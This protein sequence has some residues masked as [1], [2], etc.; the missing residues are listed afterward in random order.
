MSWEPDTEEIRLGKVRKELDDLKAST[1]FLNTSINEGMSSNALGSG[2]GVSSFNQGSNGDIPQQIENVLEDISGT[3][4]GIVDVIGSLLVINPAS[5]NEQVANQSTIRKLN[6]GVDGQKTVIK[7]AKGKTVKLI[8]NPNTNSS[9]DGNL[10]LGADLVLTD[11]ESVTLRFTTDIL[12][13]DS[14]ESGDPTKAEIQKIGGW[15]IESTGSGSGNST[16]GVLKDPV[17][18]A[19]TGNNSLHPA[20][21]S[22][23]DGI[24]MVAGD[25]FLV[26]DQTTQA[27]NGIYIWGTGT[28]GVSVR[29]SDMSHGSVQKEGTMTYVQDGLTQNE[30][31]YAINIGGNNILIGTNPNTWGEIGSGSGGGSGSIKSPVKV[32]TT[33]DVT[34]WTYNNTSGTL[35]ASGNGV[36]VI[37][38]ITLAVNNRI[39]VKNQSPANENGIYSV[40]TAGAVGA[41]LVLTRSTDM[42]TGST[43]EGG[44]M[45]YVTDGTVNG[46]NL[47]GLTTEGTV[48][49]GTGNQA[50]ANLTAG[51]VGTATS[52]LN[53]NGNAILDSTGDLQINDD[54]DMLIHKIK[55]I[56]QLWYDATGTQSI[57]STSGGI[58]LKVP[59]GD[60]ID[61]FVNSTATPK[62]GITE[63]SVES[64]VRLDMNLNY[65]E[66]QEIST[67]STPT[68]NHGLIYAKDVGGVTTPMWSNSVGETSLLVDT[69][70]F[71]TLTG[72]NNFTGSTNS[73]TNNTGTFSAYTP[74]VNLGTGA[75]TIN[76]LGRLQMSGMPI[77]WNSGLTYSVT[78]GTVAGGMDFQI[79]STSG[80]AF[81]FQIGTGISGNPQFGIT[82]TSVES[83]VALNMN[84]H[85]VYWDTG[86]TYGLVSGS[87][88]GGMDFQIP[89]TA[90]HSFDFQ[91][92]NGAGGL[93]VPQFGITDI[94]VESNVRLNVNNQAIFFDGTNLKSSILYLSNALNY[95]VDIN[96]GSHDFF[97]DDLV[98]PKLGITETGVEL[99][100]P[101]DMNL[102]YI[103]FQAISSPSAPTGLEKRFLFSDSSNSDHLSV[104]T[105]SG[106]VDLESGGGASGANDTLSNLSSPIA[107]NQTLLP[108]VAGGVIYSLGSSSAK[109]RNVFTEKLGFG[110]TAMTMPT[111][112]GNNGEVLTTNG[113]SA[114]SWTAVS[115]GSQTPW[116]TQISAGNNALINANSIQFSNQNQTSVNNSIPYIQF[117]NYDFIMNSPSDRAIELKI[118]GQGFI[119]LV[120]DAVADRVIQIQRRVD[121]SQNY[122]QFDGMSAPNTVSNEPLLFANSGNSSH[123]SIR[124]GSGSI[125]DLEASSSSGADT[126][127]NNL[128][129]TLVN[130]SLIPETD[131]V[132]SL[133]SSS[134]YWNYLYAST[135]I[136]LQGRMDFNG[137]N[138]YTYIDQNQYG[139]DF[140]T[141]YGSTW[142]FYINSDKV[143]EMDAEGM[144]VIAS[145]TSSSDRVCIR[146]STQQMGFHTGTSTNVG[147]Y[148][149]MGIPHYYGNFKTN[150]DTEFGNVNGCIGISV[151]SSG[152][153]CYLWAKCNG[154]W[155]YERLT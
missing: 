139:L 118:G 121:M 109:W 2:F 78:G 17:K 96:N 87:G 138:S 141:P 115:G 4:W 26:K 114:L 29:A 124:T 82:N 145:G 95:I 105:A 103:K 135:R 126:D 51:W 110:G 147:S 71:A 56:T 151:T 66:F 64:N 125:I 86:L 21:G 132:Q 42:S 116:T 41:T 53:M 69:S 91:V 54:I 81:D 48:T 37:D 134:K 3:F 34:S 84:G 27:D 52:D 119:S 120:G 72:S 57:Y 142:D 30:I 24:G 150:W 113:S 15:I 77:Y 130:Q 20:W 153:A 99:N 136:K 129:T 39:L 89:S 14:Y 152:G 28:L 61:F 16:S 43:I 108:N 25:R 133:G 13:K 106:V 101:L 100:V 19:T 46:D 62:L 38:G 79:P 73:F 92:G 67:P 98:T 93:G 18:V 88:A 47:F 70:G 8:N 127:L 10:L 144:K 31:L 74:M 102:S 22:T 59:T 112:A 49:V 131:G 154:T 12:Y 75:G 90:N 55:G 63:T 155:R 36:V 44:T 7:P 23:I 32:A 40:T 140:Q 65:I 122:I 35:T 1:S 58:G 117:D 68:T 137:S 80:H 146:G 5:A 94:S 97:V 104:R 148:G 149:A 83:N 76:V 9:T 107:I 128:T 6:G 11:T 111:N 50:W 85:S 45:V 60:T 33:A 143:I 123:L